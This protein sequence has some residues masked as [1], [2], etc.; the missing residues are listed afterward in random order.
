MF[1][2][3]ILVSVICKVVYGWVHDIMCS[4]VFVVFYVVSGGVSVSARDFVLCLF[5]VCLP[6]ELPL[7]QHSIVD[8]A[9]DNG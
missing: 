9:R 1:F 5:C 7:I 4:Y 8:C 6:V 3:S 2:F